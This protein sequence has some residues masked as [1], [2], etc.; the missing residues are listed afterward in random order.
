[1]LISAG[2]NNRYGHPHQETLERLNKENRI[3]Y[4]TQNQGAID[5]KTNGKNLRINVL[6][7]AGISDII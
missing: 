5:I 1:M 3:I 6:Q 4:N 7:K 2:V